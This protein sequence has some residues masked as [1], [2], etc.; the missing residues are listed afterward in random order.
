MLQESHGGR[1]TM[2]LDSR[3]A[4]FADGLTHIHPRCGP[5]EENDIGGTFSEA[6]FSAMEQCGGRWKYMRAAAQEGI[7]TFAPETG[8]NITTFLRAYKKKLSETPEA[9]ELEERNKVLK[10]L[11]KEYRAGRMPRDEYDKKWDEANGDGKAFN[12]Y[13]VA[14]HN[15]LLEMQEDYH[16][17]YYLEEW[18]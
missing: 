10:A 1:G 3:V 18:E 2:R 15:V 4:R 16:Y 17:T 6:D 8:F 7:Y 13:L 14:M 11:N 9:K 5:G 12:R